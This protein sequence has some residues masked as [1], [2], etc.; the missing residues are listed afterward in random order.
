[1]SILLIVLH[2]QSIVKQIHLVTQTVTKTLVPGL[3]KTVGNELT[4]VYVV[5]IILALIAVSLKPQMIGGYPGS[6]ANN[7]C[8][9][10]APYYVNQVVLLDRLVKAMS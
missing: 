2:E 5:C 3:V 7:R 9:S 4:S 1:M 10:Y 6:A 8:G